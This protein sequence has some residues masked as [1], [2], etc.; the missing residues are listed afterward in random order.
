M[1]EELKEKF[2]EQTEDLY[3][4]IGRFVVEFEHVCN[5]MR[6]IIMTILAKEGLSNDNVMQIL[7]SDQTA[8][9][10]RS[11]VTSLIAETQML[12]VQ[13]K[14]IINKI[15]SRVQ[16]LTKTRNDVIHGTWFIGW[17]SVGDKEFT[18]APGI[19]FKKIKKGLLLKTLTG[20]LKTLIN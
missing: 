16:D 13:E 11:V 15:T 4:A 17:A 10:L 3:A 18:E 19:K 7:L 5:Y 8:E 6:N 14:T 12:S 1:D 9:P 2:Q 20:T